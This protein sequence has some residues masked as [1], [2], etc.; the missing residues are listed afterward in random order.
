MGFEVRYAVRIQSRKKL[1]GQ[2]KAIEQNWTRAKN[3]E[4]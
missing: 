2:S 4:I 3:F 1:M